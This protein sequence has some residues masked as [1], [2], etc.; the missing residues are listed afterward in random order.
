MC[1]DPCFFSSLVRRGIRAHNCA[2]DEHRPCTGTRRALRFDDETGPP[3]VARAHCPG[4]P[5][6]PIKIGVGPP[7]F[8]THVRFR[9][10]IGV[11]HPQAHTL[12]WGKAAAENVDGFSGE[13]DLP[14][15]ADRGARLRAFAQ[16]G[17]LRR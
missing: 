14:V 13:V 16:V 6:R 7:H 1:R 11:R 3:G 12:V 2:S 15:R 5:K 9:V 4:G 8:V 17:L 10:A